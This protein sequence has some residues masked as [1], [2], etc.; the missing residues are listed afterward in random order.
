[1]GFHIFKLHKYVN[2]AWPTDRL[3]TKGYTIMEAQF[4]ATL[5]WVAFAG[6]D[7]RQGFIDIPF[8]NSLFGQRLQKMIKTLSTPTVVGLWHNNPRLLT[9]IWTRDIINLCHIFQQYI[10]DVPYYNKAHGFS[11]A[12]VSSGKTYIVATTKFYDR[13]TNQQT[14]LYHKLHDWDNAHSE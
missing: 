8:V 6:L 1:M 12:Q 3:P 2:S 9:Q 11:K 4:V 5:L 14:T 13:A 7:A 10:A